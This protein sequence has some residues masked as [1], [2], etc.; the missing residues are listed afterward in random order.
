MPE[1]ADVPKG[2]KL[3]DLAAQVASMPGGDLG[4]DI[5]L[6]RGH[7]GQYDEARTIADVGRDEIQVLVSSYDQLN[8]PKINLL[9]I[10]RKILLF[11]KRSG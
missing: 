5:I 2:K 10:L 8:L 7:G 11:R 4:A 9:A 3:V 1:N 6:G